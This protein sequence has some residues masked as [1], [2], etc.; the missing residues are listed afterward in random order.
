MDSCTRVPTTRHTWGLWPCPVIPR[1]KCHRFPR[2]H[3]VVK[4]MRYWK[5][6]K[7]AT[8]QPG[9][10]RVREGGGL[11][12]QVLKSYLPT[13]TVVRKRD[14]VDCSRVQF[15]LSWWTLLFSQE[16]WGHIR[17]RVYGSSAVC[18]WSKPVFVLVSSIVLFVRVTLLFR[19]QY[20]CNI[21][22]YLRH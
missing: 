19:R 21:F 13:S 18:Y 3:S 10:A 2:P 12:R 22:T 8:G 6:L 14:G 11:G 9:P 4:S 20:Y 1:S 5:V 7:G 17:Y 16:W 15:F